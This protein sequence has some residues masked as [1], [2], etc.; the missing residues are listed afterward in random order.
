[1][2]ETLQTMS[3]VSRVRTVTRDI[4][5]ARIYGLVPTV[6]SRPDSKSMGS[7][8]AFTRKELCARL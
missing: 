2:T 1:V 4:S 6:P 3:R 5:D 7:A 8:S